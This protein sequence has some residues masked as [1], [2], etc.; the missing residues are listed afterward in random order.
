MI[1]KGEVESSVINVKSTRVIGERQVPD[2]PRTEHP[3]ERKRYNEK[4][5]M[6]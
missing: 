6:T 4:R 3:G 5:N 2:H 1:M